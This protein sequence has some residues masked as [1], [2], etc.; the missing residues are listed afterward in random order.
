MNKYFLLNNLPSVENQMVALLELT[1]PQTWKLGDPVL[2]IYAEQ[3]LDWPNNI[4][5]QTITE[6]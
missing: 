6:S 4:N 2:V 3:L 5:D 1:M